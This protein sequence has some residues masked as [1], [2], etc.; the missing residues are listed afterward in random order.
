MSNSKVHFFVFLL[1]WGMIP[2]VF[3]QNN[4]ITHPHQE[5][6]RAEVFFEQGNH[7]KALKA[8][9]ALYE[10]GHYSEQ[11]LYRMAFLHEQKQNWTQAIFFLKKIQWRY[12]GEEIAFRLAYLQDKLE[13]RFP[14]NNHRPP[15]METYLLRS[16]SWLFWLCL[17]LLL[18][19][20]ILTLFGKKAWVHGIGLT[21][22]S[23]AL[24]IACLM[25][26]GHFAMPD[27]AVITQE[28]SFYKQAAYA[29]QRLN[30]PLEPGQSVKIEDRNDIWC[31][32]SQGSY[33]AWVPAFSLRSFDK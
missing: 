27:R 9:E 29:S 1:F 15:L 20:G 3:P 17:G 32:I 16:L 13:A 24:L 21:G 5:K 30:V 12:G 4:P 8:Y 6:L 26:F 7:E 11:S 22:L 14:I 2:S 19:G 33:R 18:I 28:T 23:F 25:V 31:K 10:A